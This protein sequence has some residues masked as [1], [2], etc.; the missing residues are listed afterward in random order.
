MSLA[1]EFGLR[2]SS[3][4]SQLELGPASNHKPTLAER[5][6]L[7]YD[8]LKESWGP[9]NSPSSNADPP[10]LPSQTTPAPFSVKRALAGYYC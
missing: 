2:R 3:K 7:L 8:S 1:D 4:R 5:R 6:N 9:V 10:P